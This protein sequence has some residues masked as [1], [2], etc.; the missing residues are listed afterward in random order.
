MDRRKFL[1]ISAGITALVSLSNPFKAIAGFD[2]PISLD[3]TLRDIE[4]VKR[5][6][7]INKFETLYDNTHYTKGIAVPYDKRLKER[8]FAF[9]H[10][11][12]L[13]RDKYKMDNAIKDAKRQ[14]HHAY[15]SSVLTEEES[16]EYYSGKNKAKWKKYYWVETNG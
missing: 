9:G 11:E 1:K 10:T 5:D 15:V 3:F 7:P 13:L 6:L 14:L 2:K 12:E 8:Y 4:T 16:K